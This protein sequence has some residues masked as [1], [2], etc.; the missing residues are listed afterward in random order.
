MKVS[1]S[2]MIATGI[3]ALSLVAGLLWALERPGC[4]LDADPGEYAK[5]RT[6]ALL[7]LLRTGLAEFEAEHGRY[8]SDA[9]GLAALSDGPDPVLQRGVDADGWGRAFRYHTI[10]DRRA[11]L[12]SL[13]PDGIDNEGA[14]DD[15]TVAPL[16]PPHGEAADLD[17][18]FENL[19]PA[20]DRDGEIVVRIVNRSNR[21]ASFYCGVEVLRD[22]TWQEIVTDVDPDSP[23]KTARVRQIEAKGGSDVTWKPSGVARTVYDA[24]PGMYR[25]IVTLWTEGGSGEVKARSP[26]FSLR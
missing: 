14:G 7:G 12:Y 21:D 8:P 23:P 2:R 20:Y 9:E 24:P 5:S 18:A 22:G 10:G 4:Q 13:G 1:T 16:D 6:M 19:G 15:M 25:F 11:Q 26:G 3:V 17:V